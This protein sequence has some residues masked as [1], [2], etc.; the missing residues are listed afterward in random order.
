MSLLQATAVGPDPYAPMLMIIGLFLGVAF[1]V[2]TFLVWLDK[3]LLN[4]TGTSYADTDL[5]PPSLITA[6]DEMVQENLGAV[7]AGE[8][9]LRRWQEVKHPVDS[10]KPFHR[11][12]QHP[13]RTQVQSFW[14][15]VTGIGLLE[16]GD[17]QAIEAVAT[18]LRA[19]I[20]AFV[21]DH[22]DDPRAARASVIAEA[23]DR[24]GLKPKPQRATVL[25]GAAK[26]W[27]QLLGGSPS[28]PEALDESVRATPMI[29]PVRALG[30]FVPYR[31]R[32]R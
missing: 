15:Y 10:S 31:A 23:A 24:A 4:F 9:L 28:D 27:Q 17:G 5:A 30:G 1:L 11:Q 25:F 22:P 7:F 13:G 16:Q 21:A 2:I 19:D 18:A 29:Y 26:A 3:G 20:A 32:V 14:G 12:Q 6:V 8:D